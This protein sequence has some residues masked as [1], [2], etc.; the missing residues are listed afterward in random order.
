MFDQGRIQLKY[1]Y[2][3][4]VAVHDPCYLGRYNGIYAPLRQVLNSLPGATIM[5]APRHRD[6]GFCCG[7]GG[8]RMWL[9]ESLGEKINHLRAKE[10]MDLNAETIATACP[11]CLTMMTDGVGAIEAEKKPEVVDIIKL[12]ADAL[13]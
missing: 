2:P 5:E 3:K 7:G 1:P 8:G 9:H 6:K 12:A 11:Y 10:F 13:G 4:S